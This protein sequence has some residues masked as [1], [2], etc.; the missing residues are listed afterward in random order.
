MADAPAEPAPPAPGPSP[1]PRKRR[2]WLRRVAYGLVALVVLVVFAPFALSIAPV[3]RWVAERVSDRLG[4]QVTI[5]GLTARWWSGTELR[6]VEVH[7]PDGSE[8]PPL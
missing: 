5:G 2:R 8:G 7:N 1:S 4:R 6:D 3:R